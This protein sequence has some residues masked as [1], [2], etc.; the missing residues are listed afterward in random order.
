ME[1][2]KELKNIK[3]TLPRGGFI[4][5]TPCGYIQ[6]GAP[7]ETI[8]DTMLL[9][10]SVPQ[11]FVLP[12]KLFHWEK[13]ISLAELEF[14]IYY[15][16]FFK[17]KKTFI[18][19]RE[20]QAEHLLKV[21]Q[22]SVFGPEILNIAA[23]FHPT[24]KD[25]SLPDLR[26]E[27]NYYRKFTFEDLLEFHYFKDNSYKLKEI[28][29]K[30]NKN[31]DFEVLT[32]N[33]SLAVIPGEIDYSPKFDIGQ[34]L[35]APY[36]PPLFGATCLGPS[37]GF[38]PK[39][40]TSGFIIWLNHNGIMVDPPVNATEW[41]EKSNVNPKLINSI[42][43]THCHADHDAGTFQ[44]ILEESRITL[45]T[46]KTILESFLRK[47]SALTGEPVEYLK[48]LFNFHPIYIGKP[49]FINGGKFEMFYSL[50]A[51]PAMGFYL[52]FQEKSIAY[53]SDHQNSPGVHKELLESEIIS[54]TRYEELSNFPW[55]ADLI[56]HESGIPPLHTPLAV[57]D[58]LKEETRKKIIIYHIAQ[59]DFPKKTNLTLARSGIENTIYLNVDP[60]PFENSYQLLSILKHLDFFQ[61]FPLEKVQDFTIFVKKENFKS[62]EKIIQKGTMGD[63]F[64][65]IGS[66][67]ISLQYEPNHPKKIYS[68]Y[69]YF[70][71]VSLLTDRKREVDVTAETDVILY[72][73]DKDHFLS[74]ISGTEFEETLKNLIRVRDKESWELLASSKTFRKLTTYQRNWLESVIHPLEKEGEGIL[75]KEGQV[76]ESLY[77]IRR[78]KIEIKKGSKIVANPGKGE[79]LGAGKNL[80]GYNRAEY[81][82]TY[83]E[84]ISLYEIHM[85]D[86]KKFIRR[87]PG[88][89]M[90]LASQFE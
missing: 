3:T 67:N 7:P 20:E 64:Y 68:M 13:G 61:T 12:R 42:I 25:E 74:F 72:T 23:D 11:V 51:I 82:V 84:P 88:L 36:K 54:R 50:H 45:Y 59:K 87:N 44:K 8:K 40:N 48:E 52:E 17:Q 37:H 57:F 30:I 69:E 33:K 56:F 26:A 78:G 58:N 62:G 76:Y 73:M 1:P 65:V 85:E 77:I 28:E 2:L 81:T 49:L 31:A 9:P 5:D 70:G 89:L 86:Y 53:S 14:P 34:R 39:E 15:N 46:T 16:F 24:L 19:C 43:L 66:G 29:I 10:Q 83:R 4:V 18:I 6:F 60:P 41:L 63:K 80:N 38:D 55:H 32:E 75:M 21:L 47:Y 27:L 90:K 79:L 71:H 35:Q 22:E